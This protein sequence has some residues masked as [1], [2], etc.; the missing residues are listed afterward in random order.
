MLVL[1]LPTLR[2]CVAIMNISIRMRF[3]YVKTVS[4]TPAVSS[5]LLML[6]TTDA[7]LDRKRKAKIHS[8]EKLIISCQI[9]NNHTRNVI[10]VMTCEP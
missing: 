6:A 1:A 5:S 10:N 4:E 7:S 9:L 3:P 8:G 2:Q